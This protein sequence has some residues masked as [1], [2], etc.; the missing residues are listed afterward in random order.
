MLEASLEQEERVLE[1]IRDS[2]KGLSQFLPTNIYIILELADKTQVF[3]DKIQVKQK[4]LQPWTGKINAKQAEIDVA[5]SER[6]A[7]A[8]KAESLGAQ[9]KEAEEALASLQSEGKIKV[10]VF[11]RFREFYVLLASVG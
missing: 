8:K 3:H 1:G 2:L 10:H 7:L 11:Y 4:E 5:T 9:V 6:D